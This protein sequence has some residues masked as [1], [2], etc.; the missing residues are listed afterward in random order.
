[1]Q[2]PVRSTPGPQPEGTESL[3]ATS[4]EGTAKSW[5]L[6]SQMVTGAR[7]RAVEKASSFT[8]VPG[9]RPGWLPQTSAPAVQSQEPLGWPCRRHQQW[10]E[11]VRGPSRSHGGAWEAGEEGAAARETKGA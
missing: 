2:T 9:A 11:G 4:P 8:P 5:C 1:M 3:R 6:V 7:P 10:R